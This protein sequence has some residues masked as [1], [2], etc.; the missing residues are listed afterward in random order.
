MPH[1]PSSCDAMEMDLY[2]TVKQKDCSGA[3]PPTAKMK[4]AGNDNNAGDDD[5]GA[6]KVPL[7]I[8]R[9]RQWAL[10]T[11]RVVTLC[12]GIEAVIQG[13]ENLGLAH[14]HVAACE[15]DRHCRAVIQENF[16]PL[17]LL[18][19]ICTLQEEDLPDHEIM[20]AGFPCQPFSPAG[21]NEGLMDRSGRGLII[22]H[23]L[24]LVEAKMPKIIVLGECRHHHWQTS[25]GVLRNC[26]RLAA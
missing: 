7:A 20:W 12:S 22:L 9:I 18:E 10:M 15:K 11:S 1:I 14:L 3:R 5:A 13:Y 25:H 26:A 21:R 17:T 8:P 23:I 19:D 2:I 4:R 6:A 24:R 16:R